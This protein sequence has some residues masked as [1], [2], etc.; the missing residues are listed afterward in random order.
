M[1][2]ACG[3]CGENVSTTAANCP[4]CGSSF[5][6]PAVPRRHHRRLVRRPV[7]REEPGAALVCGILGLL[8][9]PIFSCVAIAIGRPGKPGRILGI[10]G[11]ALW[12]AGLAFW[13]LLMGAVLAR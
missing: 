1:L 7:S 11:V 6:R 13:F 4:H 12:L 5:G 2:V 9:C 3:A 8:M 10:V